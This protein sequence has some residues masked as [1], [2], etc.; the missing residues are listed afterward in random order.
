MKSNFRIN[1]QEVSLNNEE[2][3]IKRLTAAK[4][5]DKAFSELLDMYQQRLYWHIRKFVVTHENTDDVLQNTFVRV[6]KSLPNFQQKSSL[7]TWMYRIAYNESLRFLEKEKRNQKVSIDSISTRYLDALVEDVFFDGKEIQQKLHNTLAKL[8]EKQRAIFQM[9]YFDDLKFREMAGILDLKE[10][11][12]K[13]IYYSAV[14]FIEE[15][16]LGK[17]YLEA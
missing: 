12:I 6:F 5:R 2:Q 1:E 13:T 17:V 15:Q 4:T 16:M 8:S 14:K 9:K 11:T 7:H 3:F 10:G